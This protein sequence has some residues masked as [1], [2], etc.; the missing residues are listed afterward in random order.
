VPPNKSKLRPNR[1]SPPLK[2][3][4]CLGPQTF[5]PARPSRTAH[6]RSLAHV[7][8]RPPTS[9]LRRRR[10]LRCWPH[11]RTHAP[12]SETEGTV[13]KSRPWLA[14]THALIRIFQGFLGL[15]HNLGDTAVPCRAKTQ[16]RNL[17][18]G[19]TVCVLLLLHELLHP[20]LT[21]RDA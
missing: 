7:P 2:S 14:G 1:L 15:V 17:R 3:P 20:C 8:P 19:L 4:P 12:V 9:Q 5:W 13:S 18:A 10:L 6:G 11:L 21:P 16:P